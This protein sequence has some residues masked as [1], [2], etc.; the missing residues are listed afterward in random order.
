MKMIKDSLTCFSN[1]E[2]SLPQLK[3]PHIIKEK[4]QAN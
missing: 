2:T 3:F 1:I 4:E